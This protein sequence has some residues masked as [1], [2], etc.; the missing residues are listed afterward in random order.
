MAPNART[1]N[2]L[3]R[4][5]GFTDPA[6]CSVA[7]CV[8]NRARASIGGP[9]PSVQAVTQIAP[10]IAVAT[11]KPKARIGPSWSPPLSDD[12]QSRT[13]VGKRSGAES[14]DSDLATSAY[15]GWVASLR[16]D[17]SSRHSGPAWVLKRT[18][19]KTMSAVISRAAASSAHANAPWGRLIRYIGNTRGKS[20]AS[21]TCSCAREQDSQSWL[22]TATGE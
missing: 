3:P 12:D 20:R 10:T 14:N 16:V 15:V 1:M 4:P 11:P 19:R 7:E 21:Q 5:Y 6:I 8:P 22:P 13:S 9:T 2:T 18:L 17:T